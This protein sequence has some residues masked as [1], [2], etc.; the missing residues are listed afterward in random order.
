[1]MKQDQGSQASFAS[2]EEIPET[3][4]PK[5]PPGPPPASPQKMDGVSS[6]SGGRPPPPPP[7]F[8]VE[9]AGVSRG[10]GFL[11][12]NPNETLRTFEL[13]RLTVDTTALQFGDWMSM[14]DSQMGDLSYS[15]NLW[16]GMVKSA[17]ESC[18]GEWLR[19]GPLERLRLRPTLDANASLWPRTER[20][21]VAMLLQAIP[22][23]IR[24]DL[25]SSRKMTSE[26]IIFKLPAWWGR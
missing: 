22:S 14:V 19:S 18:Y 12:E 6:G 11:G 2:A 26:Q 4:G 16:W 15:S 25:V 20:R 3:G 17:A 10:A 13:P 7:P 9:P 23:A 24:D 21:A 8:P 1:M 5:P